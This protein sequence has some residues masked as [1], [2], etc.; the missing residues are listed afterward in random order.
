MIL[1]LMLILPSVYA[2]LFDEVPYEQDI[3]TLDDGSKFK[4]SVDNKTLIIEKEGVD[5]FNISSSTPMH[6]I[7]DVKKSMEWYH[8][9][10]GIIN[11]N[12]KDGCFQD[13]YELCNLIGNKL[14]GV[15]GNTWTP[16]GTDYFCVDYTPKNLSGDFVE[17]LANITLVKGEYKV[18]HGAGYDPTSTH[19]IVSTS[20]DSPNECNNVAFNG[21]GIQLMANETVAF[22]IPFQDGVY[23]VGKNSFN[24][25]GASSTY[26][27]GKETNTRAYQARDADNSYIETSKRFN[28]TSRHHT[29]ITKIAWNE[30]PDTDF[31]IAHIMDGT[32]ANRKN[33]TVLN[34]LDDNS[35]MRFGTANTSK[36]DFDSSSSKARAIG[37]WYA[38]G[39][40]LNATPDS[41]Y[42]QVRYYHDYDT[43]SFDKDNS[44]NGEHWI[45]PSGKWTLFA[46]TGGTRELEGDIQFIQYIEDVINND[47]YKDCSKSKYGCFLEKLGNATVNFTFATNNRAN[48][49][50]TCDDTH[51]QAGCC[52]YIDYGSVCYENG[53]TDIILASGTNRNVTIYF[54]TTNSTKTPVLRN[55]TLVTWNVAV[56]DT[57][58]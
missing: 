28:A 24:F 48:I 47:V 49:S 5:V 3:K 46:E 54:N 50:F 33:G 19:K 2:G 51:N 16:E 53:T 44:L 57:T 1:T 45:N 56:G 36:N 26:V 4:K 30:G 25:T 32:L 15:N 55:I 8:E 14:G 23:D 12:C 10:S 29:I 13:G 52:A 18:I 34:I 11:H 9:K 58:D 38:F 41:S 37:T 7:G 21:N 39:V 42:P 20:C 22:L 31:T 27:A 43:D 35:S 6:Y 40:T 17:G